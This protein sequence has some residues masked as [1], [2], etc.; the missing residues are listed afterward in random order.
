[1]KQIVKNSTT[2]DAV[3]R[4][5]LAYKKADAFTEEPEYWVP[6]A[7]FR[8]LCEGVDRGGTDQRTSE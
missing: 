6:P 1:M 5:L 7:V 8:K 3:T 4:N 2:S